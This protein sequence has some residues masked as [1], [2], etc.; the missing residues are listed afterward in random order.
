MPVI[1]NFRF[2]DAPSSATVVVTLS[3]DDDGRRT[4]VVEIPDGLEQSIGIDD[5]LS[6]ASAQTSVES[7]MSYGLFVSLRAGVSLRLSGDRSVWDERWGTIVS[8]H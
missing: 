7:A 1:G 8:V 2:D 4:A 5:C 6:G 3:W